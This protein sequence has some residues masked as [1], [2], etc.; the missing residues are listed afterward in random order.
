MRRVA[1]RF[2]ISRVVL[3]PKKNVITKKELHHY[4]F[5]ISLV[6]LLTKYPKSS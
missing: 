5:D 4:I 3:F 1:G 6:M 2:V